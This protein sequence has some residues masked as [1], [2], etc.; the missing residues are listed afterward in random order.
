VVRG[1]RGQKNAAR[2]MNKLHIQDVSKRRSFAGHSVDSCVPLRLLQRCRPPEPIGPQRAR[3]SPDVC[4]HALHVRAKRDLRY[5]TRL[6][7]S[8]NAA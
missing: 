4:R 7:R 5:K 2:N 3:W 1:T 6:K 8:L